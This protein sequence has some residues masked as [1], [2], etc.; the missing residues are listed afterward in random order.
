MVWVPGL[1][2][3]RDNEIDCEIDLCVLQYARHEQASWSLQSKLEIGIGECKD[4][5][6]EIT[7]QD[8]GNMVSVYRQL[9]RKEI[10]CYLIYS[11]TSD[12]FTAAELNRFKTLKNERIP[13]ILLTNS[14]LEALYPYMDAREDDS[15][16]PMTLQEM[17]WISDRRYLQEA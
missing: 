7:E 1:K 14:E 13:Q 11:K 2:L 5:G 6:G 8:I 3:S 17:S 16:V 4:E 15:R 12:S 9:D 10:R